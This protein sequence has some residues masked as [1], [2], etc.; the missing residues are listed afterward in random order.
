V[1]IFKPEIKFLGHIISD[2]KVKADRERT[3]AI[4]RYYVPK[5]QR[6]LR[7]FLGICNFHQQFIL[8]YSLY[9]EPL[10]ILLRKG[11][12]WR[13][14]DALQQSFETLRAKFARSIQ[15]VH[16]DEQKGWIINSD[17]SSRAIGSVLLQERDDGGFNIVSTASRVLNQTEQRYTTCEKE[18]LAVVYALQR[19]RI[20]IYGR[21]VTLF[22]DNKALSFS[23]RCVITSNRVARWMVQI[24]EY[25]LEIR[26]IREVQN[27]LAD[28]LSRNPNGMTDEQIRNLTRPDQVMIHHIQVYKNKNFKKG[29]KALAELQDTDEKL[30]AIKKS[31]KMPVY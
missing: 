15:L 22:T 5:K 8:N 27:H 23:H 29:L 14:T 30:A 16:P 11:N 9:I 31:Y 6:Q 12:K 28:I 10:L 25:D 20:Y 18:L 17:A 19:S 4:L 1:R 2:E 7:K 13:W 3:E 26:Y 21:K 24:Q